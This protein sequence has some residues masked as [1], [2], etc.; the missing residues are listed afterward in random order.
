[1]RTA[2]AALTGQRWAKVRRML[3]DARTL[4][5]LDQ[6]HKE[7]TAAEPCNKRL[8]ALAALWRWQRQQRSAGTSTSTAVREFV[9]VVVG[10][11]GRGGR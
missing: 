8:A 9:G 11:W 2:T 4:P 5:I 10:S 7:L 1:M 6:L 3:L